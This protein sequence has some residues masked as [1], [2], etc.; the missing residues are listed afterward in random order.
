MNVSQA[1]A[2]IKENPSLMAVA[3]VSHVLQ[4]IAESNRG[5]IGA[6]RPRSLR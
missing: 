2:K 5:I 4:F 1:V 6:P 3:E